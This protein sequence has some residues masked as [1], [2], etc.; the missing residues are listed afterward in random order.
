MKCEVCGIESDATFCADHSKAFDQL[1]DK[2][3][4]WAR[5]LGIGWEAYLQKI[6]TNPNTGR[7]AREVAEHF[8][9]K[10]RLQKH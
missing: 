9:L 1:R 7:W 4:V 3:E 6:S 2:F 8:L 5:A 10:S